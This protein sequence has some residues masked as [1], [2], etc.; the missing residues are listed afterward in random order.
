MITPRYD[1]APCSGNYCQDKTKIEN[2]V[3]QPNKK[4]DSSTKYP[5]SL[6]QLQ[7]QEF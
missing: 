4:Q 6:P 1:F 5:Q 3:F 7:H 2:F